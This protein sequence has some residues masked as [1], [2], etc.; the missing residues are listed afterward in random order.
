V[1]Q[2]DDATREWSALEPILFWLD[3]VP[4]YSYALFS[5]FGMLVGAMWAWNEFRRRN[6]LTHWLRFLLPRIALCAFL[7]ARVLHVAF[8]WH[9]YNSLHALI[10]RW[11]PGMSFHGAML[12]SIV[13]VLWATYQF[14]LPLWTVLDALAPAAPLGHSIGRVG[15]FLNGCCYGKPTNVPWAVRF[16]NRVLCPDDLT[17]HPTQLYEAVGLLLLFAFLARYPSTSRGKRFWLWVGGYGLLRFITEFWRA[18]SKPICLGL[19]APQW[20]SVAL[21]GSAF[22]GLKFAGEN[23]ARQ[24]GSEKCP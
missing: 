8:H 14:R 16:R 2:S 12:G 20:L 19:T 5:I 10:W 18:G 11:R 6:L 24:S 4:I 9:D 13:G 23:F 22:W 1:S 7:G 17:R 15:C 21:I 3:G